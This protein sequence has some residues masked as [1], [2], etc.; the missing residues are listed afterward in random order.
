M[1]WFVPKLKSSSGV[2]DYKC[3][4]SKV[5]CVGRNYRA[6]AAELNNPV[7]KEPLLFIKPNTCL[8][9]IDAPIKLPDIDSSC[10]HELEVA[11][12][13]GDK[14]TDASKEQVISSIVGVGIALD[15]TLREVQSN[16][17]AKGHPWEK[18]KAF[19]CSCPVSI[20]EPI[21]GITD[22]NQLDF[23][24]T[25]NGDFVQNGLVEQ[26]IFSIPKLLQEISRHFTLLPGDIVLTGTPE[27]VGPLYSGDELVFYMQNKQ[28]AVSRV[29]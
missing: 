2:I 26:M 4:T 5:V 11:L 3:A 15:L 27:G 7:P 18:S 16:L 22:L 10:H 20:F 8:C 1:N 24:M 29:E 21:E 14:L 12:L 28:I 13:I 25:K 6:H 19:D 9:P 23:G 17:K